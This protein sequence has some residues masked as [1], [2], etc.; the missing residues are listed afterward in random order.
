ML[1]MVNRSRSG[2]FGF[3]TSLLDSFKTKRRSQDERTT[4]NHISKSSQDVASAYR[5]IADRNERLHRPI[6]K[7]F[8]SKTC[9]A[10]LSLAHFSIAAPSPDAPGAPPIPPPGTPPPP[11]PGDPRP[12][13]PNPPIPPKPPVPIPIPPAPPNPPLPTPIPPA[14]PNP[15]APK[16]LP[17][18]PP[19][20]PVPSTP[21]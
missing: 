7:A 19:I 17:P 8:N 15:P 13:P 14:P 18:A 21:P 3:V 11:R 2:C 9:L 5:E 12:V 1:Q 10:I 4:K 20:P 16:P 6:M